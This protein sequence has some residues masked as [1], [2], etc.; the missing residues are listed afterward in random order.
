[1][2]IITID[3][4]KTSRFIATNVKIPTATSGKEEKYLCKE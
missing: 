2:D 4:R 3:G 1:V